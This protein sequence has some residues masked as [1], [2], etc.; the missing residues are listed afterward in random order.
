[1]PYDASF[2]DAIS[3]VKKLMNFMHAINVVQFLQTGALEASFFSALSSLL[4][5]DLFAEVGQVVACIKFNSFLTPDMASKKLRQVAMASGNPSIEYVK[6]CL[7]SFFNAMTGVKKRI[8]FVQ[9]I[10]CPTPA[11]ESPIDGYIHSGS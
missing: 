2:F 9:P 1:M 4:Y 8:K 5:E 10:T 6:L 11:Y 3:G 7:T